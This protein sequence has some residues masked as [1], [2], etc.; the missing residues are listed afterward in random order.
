[1]HILLWMNVM[2]DFICMGFA[3]LGETGNK[4]TSRFLSKKQYVDACGFLSENVEIFLF[5]WNSG[6]FK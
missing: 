6:I 2:L 4:Q 3:E 1:M 5:F